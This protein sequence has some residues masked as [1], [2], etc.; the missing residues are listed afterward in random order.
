MGHSGGLGRHQ[1]SNNTK[2]PI[3]KISYWEGEKNLNVSVD[4]TVIFSFASLDHCVISERF[5]HGPF[6]SKK[7]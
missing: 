3:L 6:W 7:I 4:Q 1:L 5:V 2:C